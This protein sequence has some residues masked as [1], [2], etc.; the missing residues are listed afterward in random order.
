MILA[1]S[2]VSVVFNR[3]RVR[4]RATCI[5]RIFIRWWRITAS[6]THTPV[7]T[8]FSPWRCRCAARRWPPWDRTRR[9]SGFRGFRLSVLALLVGEEVCLRSRSRPL[10]LFAAAAVLGCPHLVELAQSLYIDHVMTMLCTAGFVVLLRALRP[11]CLG[12]ILFSA[13]IM[14]QMV[15]VKYTGCVFALVWGAMLF[16][17]SSAASRLAHRRA[18]VARRLLP[19]GGRSLA[20]VRL[21][22]CRHRQSIFSLFALLVSFALLGRW[23]HHARRSLETAFQARSGRCRRG[24]VSLD[25][26]LP[27]F[28]FCGSLRR[29]PGV[30]GARLGGVLVPGAAEPQSALRDMAIAGVAMIAGI[31]VYTP[32]IRYWLPAYP[33]LIAAGVLA[34]ASLVNSIGWRPE[35]RWPP[36]LVGIVAAAVLL[37]PVPLFSGL[38]WNEYSNR[39]SIA[40][41]LA[42]HFPEYST[43]L[44]LNS[45]LAPC[46]GVLCTGC[47]GIYMIAG[48]AYEFPFWWNPPHHIHDVKS[49]AGFCRDNNIRYWMV[50]YHSPTARILCGGDDIAAEYWTNDR[51][52][53]ANGSAAV[54]DVTEKR[55]LDWRAS[56]RREWPTVLEAAGKP[57]SASDAA[58]NWVNMTADAAA[59]SARRRHPPGRS[60]ADRA[61]HRAGT[62]G[63][64]LQSATRSMVERRHVRPVGDPLVRR[65]RRRAGTRRRLGL[66]KVGPR[67]KSLR[68]CPAKR[69]ERVGFRC[70][71][72]GLPS[73]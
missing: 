66:G 29:S 63:K 59:R 70:G 14:G 24:R 62:R 37:L 12:G 3:D 58:V 1:I 39:L 2:L 43:V 20:L 31:V 28:A 51:L 26:H 21:R 5:C 53:M 41:Q 19:V 57:W 17:R 11:P 30:L 42:S 33:L 44:R 55:P 47:E 7:G 45:I 34:A 61:P 15:Q 32:C 68:H 64:P 23:L 46:E 50:G 36:V 69:Q 22:L 52:V 35:G 54:Y 38:K 71:R 72:R 8:G 6:R 65:Q 10:G 48:R 18:L 9:P 27:L 13:A 56:L 49:F 73:A 16:C 60:T 4:F 40:D 67:D 25:R